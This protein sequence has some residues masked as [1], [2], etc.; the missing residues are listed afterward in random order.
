MNEQF[1]PGPWRKRQSKDTYSCLTLFVETCNGQ[2]IVELIDN[3]GNNDWFNNANL[4]AAAPEMYVAL[5]EC[6]EVLTNA[7]FERG[8][9]IINLINAA[10]S[11]A[12]PTINQS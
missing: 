6:R 12:N 1:T 8:S 9:F 2:Q 11:K 7:G 5:K 10:L 4:I 3:E